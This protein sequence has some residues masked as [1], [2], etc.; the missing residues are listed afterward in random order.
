MLPRTLSLVVASLLVAV[1]LAGCAKEEQPP[2]D[3]TTTTPTTP[4]G[5][6]PTTPTDNGTATPPVTPSP[7]PVSDK[8]AIQGQFE[9]SWTIDVPAISPKNVAINFNL[10]G[11]Q[12]GAPVTAHVTLVLTGPD[13]A[14]LK[15]A[16][17]GLGGDGDKVA[18]TLSAGDIGSAGPLT[19]KAT[20]GAS[21]GGPLPGVP[22][23][24]VGNYDLYAYVEY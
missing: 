12:A 19:L 13:N 2:P 17:L 16:Q 3:S 4:T 9:K 6:T 5:T 7:A 15:T 24:G 23:G 11:A 18:W 14:V 1:A 8:G 10:T 22:S 21:P 20:T